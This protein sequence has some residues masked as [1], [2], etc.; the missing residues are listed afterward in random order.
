MSRVRNKNKETA[1]GEGIREGIRG[2]V[3]NSLE[4]SKEIILDS[5]KIVFVGNRELTVENYKSIV[6]YT[7]DCIVVETN[8]HRLRLCGSELEI[9]SIAREMLFITGRLSSLEFIGEV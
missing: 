1:G 9:R 2:R 4:V 6:E 5:A 3:A 7:E 8:P